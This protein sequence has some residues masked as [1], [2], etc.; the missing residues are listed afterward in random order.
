[1]DHHRGSGTTGGVRPRAATVPPSTGR[2]DGVAPGPER[3][4]VHRCRRVRPPGAD[5]PL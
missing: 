1:G 3:A 2:R 4:A 5:D